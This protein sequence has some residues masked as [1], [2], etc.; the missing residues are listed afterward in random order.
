VTLSIVQGV[1]DIHA[2]PKAELDS[3]LVY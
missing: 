3:E 1:L 2:V